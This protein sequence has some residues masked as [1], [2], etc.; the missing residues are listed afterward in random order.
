MISE[1]V[2]NF[3]AFPCYD[4]ILRS[5]FFIENATLQNNLYNARKEMKKNIVFVFLH[6]SFCALLIRLL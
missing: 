5:I 6:S 1:D 3:S 2:R 4:L